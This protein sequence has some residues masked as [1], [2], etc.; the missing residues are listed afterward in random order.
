MIKYIVG[1]SGEGLVRLNN[2]VTD[3]FTSSNDRPDTE[4]PSPLC[5]PPSTPHVAATVKEE[6]MGQ[7]ISLPF[8]LLKHTTTYYRGFLHY[9]IGKG[10]HSSYSSSSFSPLAPKP[11]D[12][13]EERQF[14]Q[15]ARIHLYSLASTFYLYNKPHYRKGS[16]RDD[17]MDNLRNVA[18]PGTGIPLHWMASS[19]LCAL[20]FLTWSYPTLSLIASVHQW[21]KT[22][23]KSSIS[24][25][26]ATRL[27]A[28]ND[29]FNY[30]RLNCNIV[31]LH[32][33]LNGEAVREDYDMENKWTF[34]EQ[35]Q[36]RG[37]PVSPY[38]QTP[39]VVVKH[40]NEEGG[41]GIHFFRNATDGGDWIIQ[42]RLLNSE[43]VQSM[44]PDNA[45]LSTFRVITCS[46]KSHDI[47][48][49]GTPSDVTALSC[50]FRAGRAGAA[51]DH[52]SILFDVDVKTG[53]ILGGTTNAHWYRLWTWL[54][55]PWRSHHDYSVHPD[56][57]IPVT[58][59]QVPDIKKVLALV[60]ESHLKLCPNVPLSGWD[61]VFSTDKRV[62]ICLLET[63]LS[64]NFFRG[65][66]DL[67][68]YLDF[69][70][71]SLG[72]SQKLRLEADQDKRKF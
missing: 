63:N 35:G 71:A 22:R 12:T 67:Q 18:V 32:S 72:Q 41:L 16:Y 43:W 66:F 17:L 3:I 7:V 58:G 13:T 51:T 10:R 15:H 50:V 31:G 33:L 52:D 11:K 49:K 30:W 23:G 57:E 1:Q 40:R 46:S 54:T 42:E 69:C 45:P 55:C 36:A 64:C 6:T 24:E 14:K 9:W 60:E 37:V 62:P 34:L 47:T 70:D 65:S 38:L 5:F 28:P 44:L 59:N 21:I 20:G 53:T 61:V 39:A 56:G 48:K 25:E 4:N 19:R 8:K 27:L 26:Y 29:W 68:T 2:D